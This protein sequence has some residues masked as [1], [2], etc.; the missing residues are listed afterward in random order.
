MN[1]ILLTGTVVDT[2]RHHTA[3]GGNTKLEFFVETL[4][5]TLPLRFFVLA[6]GALA[7]SLALAPRD[8]VIIVGRLEPNLKDGRV[9]G[10]SL[11]ANN[12]EI[13]QPEPPNAMAQA[14]AEPAR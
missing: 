4:T 1:A 11:L 10:F 13:I 14:F 8:G 3:T 9:A 5:K 12:V 2:P 6:F 7:D